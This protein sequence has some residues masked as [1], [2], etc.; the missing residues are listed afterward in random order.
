[1]ANMTVSGMAVMDKAAEIRRDKEEWYGNKGLA[2]RA[3]AGKVSSGIETGQDRV[4]SFQECMDDAVRKENE[5]FPAG[6]DVVMSNPPAYRTNYKVDKNKAR[7][8]LTLDEYKQWICNRISALPVSDSMRLCRSGILIFKEEAFE[9]MKSDPAYE[10]EVIR[11]LQEDFSKELSVYGPDVKYQVI[12]GTKEECYGA[13]IPIKSYSWMIG[14][15]N[16]FANRALSAN[17]ISQGNL[18]SSILLANGLLER[19]GLSTGGFG[20]LGYAALPGTWDN[21]V[22]AY[23]NTAQNKKNAAHTHTSNRKWRG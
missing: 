4:A 12:G 10:E 19:S 16:S 3:D 9:K 22:N 17:R 23:R 18:S 8:E 1:M 14:L 6:E 21:M 7:E 11:M 15:Q 2:V 13:S 20:G 5:I